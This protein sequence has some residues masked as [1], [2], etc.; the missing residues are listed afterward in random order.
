MSARLRE[1]T[2]FQREALVNH[3][4]EKR[5]KERSIKDEFKES[6]MTAPAKEEGRGV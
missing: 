4:R 2:G 3:K 6:V 1:R 5:G